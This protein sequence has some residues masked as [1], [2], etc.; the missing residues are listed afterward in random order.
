MYSVTVK[1][2]YMHKHNNYG[3]GS[4]YMDIII[5][6]AQFICLGWPRIEPSTFHPQD[7]IDIYLFCILSS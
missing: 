5:H 4:P 2:N 1:F 7:E 6:I 3:R